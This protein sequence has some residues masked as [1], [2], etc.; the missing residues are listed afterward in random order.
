MGS[1]EPSSLGW[2]MSGGYRLG[3]AKASR[4]ICQE[5][6]VFFSGEPLRNFE[7]SYTLERSLCWQSI[8]R[9]EFMDKRLEIGTQVGR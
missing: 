1:S 4:E 8:G 7:Q 9:G 3:R 6:W 2:Q 5:V